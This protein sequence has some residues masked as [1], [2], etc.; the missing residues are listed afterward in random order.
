MEMQELEG[1][2]T[3]D[4]DVDRKEVSVVFELPAT[5]EKIEQLLTEINYPVEKS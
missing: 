5:P 1:V 4:V 3:I 2:K